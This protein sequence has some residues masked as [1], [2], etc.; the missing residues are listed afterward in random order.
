MVERLD[1]GRCAWLSCRWFLFAAELMAAQGRSLRVIGVLPL[2][3]PCS[4]VPPHF[5]NAQRPGEFDAAISST[6]VTCAAAALLR[7]R[8]L[9]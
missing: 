8:W 3:V 6:T 5:R 4:P 9:A 2:P 1:D 7:R